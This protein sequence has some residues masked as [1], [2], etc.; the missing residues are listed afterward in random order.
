MILWFRLLHINTVDYTTLWLNIFNKARNQ[1]D[2]ANGVSSCQSAKIMSHMF[3][4]CMNASILKYPDNKFYVCTCMFSCSKTNV[5]INIHIEGGVES[6]FPRQRGYCLL[7]YSGHIL[8][9]MRASKE[10]EN[11]HQDTN[12]FTEI[13]GKIRQVPNFF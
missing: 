3:L 9:R 2:C 1:D 13:Y 8:S 11:N 12:F 5:T 7:L 10:K 6:T 4:L